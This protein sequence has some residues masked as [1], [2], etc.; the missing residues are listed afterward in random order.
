M[1][2]IILAGGLGTRLNAVVSNVPKPMALVGGKPFLEILLTQL[3]QKGFKRIILSLGY[4]AEKI[5]NYFDDQYLGMTITYVIE[6]TPLG[7]GGAINLAAKRSKED[8]FFVFNGDTYLDLEVDA[9]C[10]QYHLNGLPIIVGREVTEAGRFG[11]LL[12]KNSQV[13]GFHEKVDSTSS[14]INAGCYVL[15]K[16]ILNKYQFILPCSLESDF[17][18]AVLPNWPFDLFLST[19]LFIDIGIPE[20]YYKSQA[21]LTGK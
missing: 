5:I 15:N 3:A 6:T 8:Y 14:I 18:P 13:V 20:D 17:F 11:T 16:E 1:E 4:M 7:T 12:I 10:N 19:G 2:A 9:V 21:L